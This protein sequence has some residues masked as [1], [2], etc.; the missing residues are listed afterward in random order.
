M[1]ILFVTWFFPPVNDVAALRTGA[2]ARRLMDDGHQV[3]VLTAARAHADRSLPVPICESAIT[4]TPWFDIDRFGM[5]PAP[6]DERAAAPALSAPA[7][8]ASSTPAKKKRKGPF[9]NLSA[10]R[11]DLTHIPDRQTGWRGFAIREGRRLMREK[12]IDLILASAPPFSCHL[13]AKRLGAEFQVPWIAEYRD[14]WSRYAYTPRHPWRQ[15]LDEIMEDRTAPTAAAIIAVTEPWA[16]YYKERFGKPTLA[17]YNGYDEDMM[18]A[19]S[20][21]IPAFGPVSITYVGGLYG[22]LRDPSALYRAIAA[23]GLS[24]QDVRIAYYG[25]GEAEVM[26]LAQ[27]H[28]VAGHIV[29]GGRVPYQRSLQ[30]QRDSDVLLLLQSPDDPRN[31]PAKLFE[32]F[33]SRRPILGIGLDAGIPARFIRERAAGLYSSDPDAIAAA[34]RGWRD[35]KAGLGKIPDLPERARAGLSRGRQFDR[36]REILNFSR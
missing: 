13:I 17:I 34:L 14:A 2:M 25:P 32:Y 10:L 6:G 21:D 27:R 3:H 1:N 31:V 8:S 35:Q 19:P 18:P 5:A 15:R 7:A 11:S 26:P 29:L 24:P 4:R 28:G 12:K 36:L 9:S 20:P 30:I 22:G 16:D 23:S 33:A